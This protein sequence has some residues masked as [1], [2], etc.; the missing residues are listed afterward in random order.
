MIVLMLLSCV[1]TETPVIVFSRI[2]AKCYFISVV[3][4]MPSAFVVS[5][6]PLLLNFREFI[7]L[8]NDK[9]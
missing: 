1:E 4:I 2:C 9:K 3:A 5:S 6:V 8:Y 7:A